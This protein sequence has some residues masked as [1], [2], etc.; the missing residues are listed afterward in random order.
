MSQMSQIPPSD[1]PAAGFDPV[2]LIQSHQ[3]GLWRYLRSLGATRELADDL[4]QETFLAILQKPFDDYEPAATA[5]Y[6]RTV[7]RNLLISAMRREGRVIAV[8][9]I[10][11][12]EATWARWVGE[13]DGEELL[14]KLK[15]CL[16]QL[17]ERAR[18]AL[19]MRFRDRLPRLEIAGQLGI[20]EHGAKNLMQRAKQQ[21][22]TCIDAKTN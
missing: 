13:D 6:L 17:T 10:E 12:V 15:D 16:A 5:S 9:D 1:S 4:V 18:W 3:A 19:Q 21:L 14:A 7:A 22:R 8:E 20:T 2:R 11:L